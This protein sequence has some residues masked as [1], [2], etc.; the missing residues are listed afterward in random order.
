MTPIGFANIAFPKGHWP[1]GHW[2]IYHWPLPSSEV[3]TIPS[4]DLQHT[5]C[6]IVGSYLIA[7]GIVSLPSLSND[8]PLYKSFMPETISDACTIYDTIPFIDKRI[9]KSYPNT[10][11]GLQIKIRT[12]DYATGEAKAK[13]ILAILETVQNASVEFGDYEYEIRTVRPVSGVISLGQEYNNTKRRYLFTINFISA[14]KY[15]VAA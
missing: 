7:N 13:M 3:I 8:W 15:M 6:F 4:D 2:P 11:Y 9:S 5:P 14:L 12:S 10:H 1:D